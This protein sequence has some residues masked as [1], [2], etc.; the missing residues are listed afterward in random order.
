MV[1]APSGKPFSGM[2]LRNGGRKMDGVETET[3]VCLAA[4]E[5]M[6]EKKVSLSEKRFPNWTGLW[7]EIAIIS[8]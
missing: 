4:G 1:P 2:F 3:H 6:S 8:P 7:L 5:K